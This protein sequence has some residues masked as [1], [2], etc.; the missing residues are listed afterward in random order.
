[1]HPVLAL[2][3]DVHNNGNSLCTKQILLHQLEHGFN[4]RPHT[5]SNETQVLASGKEI[6]SFKIS[7]IRHFA[8]NLQSQLFKAKAHHCRLASSLGTPKIAH[9]NTL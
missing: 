5:D 9:Y 3:E 2:I 8:G 4:I 6:A 1:M 7:W